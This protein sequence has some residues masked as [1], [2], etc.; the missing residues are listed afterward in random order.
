[1]INAQLKFREGYIMLLRPFD[2][3]NCPPL[4]KLT[5]LYAYSE[6]PVI[7][8]VLSKAASEKI[9]GMYDNLRYGWMSPSD[10]N[11]FIE[12]QIHGITQSP[13][14]Y[15]S[16]YKGE[17]VQAIVNN[18]VCRFYPDEYTVLSPEKM[19]EIMQ[20]EGYHAVCNKAIYNLKNFNDAVFYLCQRGVSR[21]IAEKWVSLTFKGLVLYKPYFE[22]LTTFCRPHEI[23]THDVFYEKNENV[24][25]TSIIAE[26]QNYFENR[27]PLIK[28][29]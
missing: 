15:D 29:K 19:T 13:T 25:F 16:I 26:K 12:R 14:A 24:D 23:L 21:K 2:F 10:K 28:L 6:Q 27:Q 4:Q 18:E 11:E 20:E 3:G 22:L 7:E 5:I 8:K 1:M 9:E 17:I